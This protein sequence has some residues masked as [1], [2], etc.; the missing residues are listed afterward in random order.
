ML[1][2]NSKHQ[3]RRRLH[4]KTDQSTP[5]IYQAECLDGKTEI[6]D[7]IEQ[8]SLKVQEVRSE[9]PDQA[10][11]AVGPIAELRWYLLTS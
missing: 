9:H 8:L 6:L 7:L 5:T 11:N 10:A 2:W 4:M 3:I 1:N